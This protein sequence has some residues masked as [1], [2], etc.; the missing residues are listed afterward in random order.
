M[1]EQTIGRMIELLVNQMSD[2]LRTVAQYSFPACTS[3]CGCGARSSVGDARHQCMLLPAD[4]DFNCSSVPFF[5]R[6]QRQRQHGV[7]WG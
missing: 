6:I 4:K 5:W 7:S 2:E 1:I 3:H